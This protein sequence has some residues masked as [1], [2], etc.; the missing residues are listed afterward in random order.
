MGLDF[1]PASTCGMGPEF[2]HKTLEFQFRVSL[3]IVNDQ[4]NH[5]NDHILHYRGALGPDCHQRQ[6][7]KIQMT[8]SSLQ[9]Q[10]IRNRGVA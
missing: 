8:E 1:V 4:S 10:I 7:K 3:I 9:I 5:C 6:R 2:A